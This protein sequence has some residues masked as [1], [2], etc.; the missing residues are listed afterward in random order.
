MKAL[1][2][3]RTTALVAALAEVQA[4]IIATGVDDP[5]NKSAAL[6]VVP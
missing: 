6:Q 4:A 1:N 3:N 5:N 2:V